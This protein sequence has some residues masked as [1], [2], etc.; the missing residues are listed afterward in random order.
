MGNM[1]EIVQWTLN[2]SS[3]ILIVFLIEFTL[4]RKM[5]K[6]YQCALWTVVLIR[7]LIPNMPSSSW[8]LLNVVPKD[9]QIV[10]SRGS[11]L[12][13]M[14]NLKHFV[15]EQDELGLAD[16]VMKEGGQSQTQLAYN[17]TQKSAK[18][19]SNS[20][21]AG[22]VQS[23]T[24][25]NLLS[26]LFESKSLYIIWLIGVLGLG[27]YWTVGYTRAKHKIQRL[28]D[29]SDEA[30]LKL[31]EDCKSR[32]MG[33]DKGKNI[34]LAQ[35]HYSMIFGIL[36][37]VITLPGDKSERVLEMCLLHELTHY[38][39]K[40]YLM[41]YV[42]LIALSFHWFNPL[43]WL[44]VRQMKLD[45]E[46]SCDERVIALGVSKKYYASTLLEMIPVHQPNKQTPYRQV[47]VFA[48]GMGSG[49]HEV[50]SRIKKIAGMKK[51]RLIG[52]VLS[53][54]L[55]SFLTVGCLTDAP[56]QEENV[57]AENQEDVSAIA[58]Q[59]EAKI[60]NI[61][62]FGL[63]S[64]GIR[65]DTIF[66]GSINDEE[67]SLKITS[68]PR[69]TKIVLDDTEKAQ[70]DAQMEQQSVKCRDVCKLSELVAYSGKPLMEKIVLK[71]IEKLT[72][73]KIDYYVLIDIEA[74]QKMIDAMGGLEID[75]PQAMNYDDAEQDLHIHLEAGK[76][77]LDGNQTMQLVMFRHSSDYAIRYPDGD[78]GR[79]KVTQSVIKEIWQKLKDVSNTEDFIRLA[80]GVSESVDTNLPLSDL[81]GYYDLL[82]AVG[83]EGIQ[84]DILSGEIVSE[85][86]R[87][88]YAV[89]ESSRY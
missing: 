63:D 43:V 82:N 88:Y 23:S 50:K 10:S 79:V 37:P 49:T 25:N 84:F 58:A 14:Q 20:I 30:V 87:S 69:D 3:I 55:V 73:I 11:Q 60:Q 57:T 67:G 36:K 62:V 2:A 33:Q 27:S 80:K 35:G 76:Q 77:H 44:A 8:S 89:D 4:G 13:S 71:K 24:V 5:K 81:K 75:V 42:Q 64:S 74:A 66:V 52:S 47:W 53:L 15:E 16:T 29:V 72:G 18:A 40:D 59:E 38:R 86:G 22:S 51:R 6:T 32:V 21:Q 28:N 70:I 12:D 34:R 1:G 46:Y 41:T 7:L 65:A 83:L 56:S 9:K 17:D 61:A 31:F 85:G 68:I 78:V 39:Y 48:Q 45:I 26:N 54:V 19:K